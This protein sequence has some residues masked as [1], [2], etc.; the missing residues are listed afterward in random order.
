MWTE[1]RLVIPTKFQEVR[2]LHRGKCRIWQEIKYKLRKRY[3]NVTFEADPVVELN[4]K[5]YQS[6][7][8]IHWIFLAYKSSKKCIKN[9]STNIPKEFEEANDMVPVNVELVNHLWL[10]NIFIYNLKTFKAIIFQAIIFL[11][12]YSHVWSTI[13]DCQLSLSAY[14]T[15][16][17]LVLPIVYHVHCRWSKCYRSMRG[18]GSQRA[19]RLCT[20]R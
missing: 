11:V 16:N 18:C 6:C 9:Q 3:L 20:P 2:H 8:F 15:I 12:N 13:S 17:R 5:T 14:H 19:R 7:N 10:P 1:P 4:L